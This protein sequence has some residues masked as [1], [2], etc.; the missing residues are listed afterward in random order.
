MDIRL[1]QKRV[2]WQTGRWAYHGVAVDNQWVETGPR[3]YRRARVIAW[4]R[5]S[6]PGRVRNQ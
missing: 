2:G 6:S 1:G 3:V 4:S 5:G